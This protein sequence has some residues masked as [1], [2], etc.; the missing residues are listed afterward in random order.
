MQ[1]FLWLWNSSF[2]LTVIAVPLASVCVCVCVAVFWSAPCPV[3][4]VH[5]L[6]GWEHWW[7]HCFPPRQPGVTL[8]APPANSHTNTQ[9]WLTICDKKDSA[10][11]Q[12]NQHPFNSIMWKSWS[13]NLFVFLYCYFTVFW[14]GHFYATKIHKSYS[15]CI[16]SK[17]NWKQQKNFCCWKV[18]MEIQDFHPSE[19]GIVCFLLLSLLIS[20]GTNTW[21]DVFCMSV[22]AV[23]T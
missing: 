6:P 1:S 5:T 18:D 8:S 22:H 14:L 16:I 17:L 7:R 2:L 19:V 11:G 9:H 13:P 12:E 23:W 4:P 20:S 3:C 15:N 10:T 21:M